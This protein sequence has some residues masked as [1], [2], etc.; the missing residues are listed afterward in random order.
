ML[1][2]NE[3]AYTAKNIRKESIP[4]MIELTGRI[5]DIWPSGRMLI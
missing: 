1:L 4:P 5:M 3:T 2:L